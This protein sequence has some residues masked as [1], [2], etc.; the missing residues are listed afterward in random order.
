MTS[1]TLA[2]TVFLF[3]VVFS[4]FSLADTP[5]LK[6]LIVWIEGTLGVGPVYDQEIILT[7]SE[8]NGTW[9]TIHNTGNIRDTLR[10]E[11]YI[12]DST[13]PPAG[14]MCEYKDWIKFSFKCG[15]SVGICDN[16]PSSETKYVDQIELTP[17]INQTSFYLE[18]TGY[19]ITPDPSPVGI[20]INGY[21]LTNYTK[22]T[23]FITIG[24]K[25][26]NP[27][28]TYETE[29]LPGINP[30]WLPLLIFLASL[31]FYKKLV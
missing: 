20:V 27:S 12:N 3:L 21:S 9:V 16:Q 28:G 18:V 24:I 19:K 15:E 10:M 30:V 14:P 8:T 2:L 25:V 23:D 13:C 11:G 6:T 31:A 29:E 17:K 5:Q 1:K 4:A 22:Q 26:K 7:V